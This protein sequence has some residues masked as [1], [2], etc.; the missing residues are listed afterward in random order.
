MMVGSLAML[1]SVKI[2]PDMWLF[3]HSSTSKV[4]G[5]DGSTRSACRVSCFRTSGPS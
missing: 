4:I 2:S 1:F 5:S 3:A